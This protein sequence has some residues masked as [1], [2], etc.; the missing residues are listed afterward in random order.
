MIELNTWQS[1]FLEGI[2][3]EQYILDT[4]YFAGGTNLMLSYFHHRVSDDLDFFTDQVID[5]YKLEDILSGLK[6]ILEVTHIHKQRIYDRNIYIF[7]YVD[8]FQLKTEF[9]KYQS[10]QF[11]LSTYNGLRTEHINDCFLNKIAAIYD[12]FDPKDYVDIYYMMYK[13]G[14]SWELKT[15]YFEKKFGMTISDYTLGMTIHHWVQK[16]N[17]FPKMEESFDE[18]LCKAFLIELAQ[19]LGY[20]QLRDLT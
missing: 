10:P 12:R 18:S 7:E 17:V 9:T 6:E 15:E 13:W 11:P 19:E 8:G 16:I 3:Q 5:I 4:F 1:R 2:A 14:C 20:H